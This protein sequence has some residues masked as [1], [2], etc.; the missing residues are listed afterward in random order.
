MGSEG[1]IT[2]LTAA[3]L[4]MWAHVDRAVTGRDVTESPPCAPPES[5]P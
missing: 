5:S 2:M 4:L 1:M 3:A